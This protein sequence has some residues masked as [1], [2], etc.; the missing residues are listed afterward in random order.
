MKMRVGEL[1]QLVREEFMR[2]VPEWALREATKKYVDEIRQYV[3]RFIMMNKSETNIDQQEAMA[4]A[5]EV[6]EELEDKAYNL[7]EDQLYQFIRRV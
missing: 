3:K 6:L 7:L 2:G 4:I 5:N 1:R